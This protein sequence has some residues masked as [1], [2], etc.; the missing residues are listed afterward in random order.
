MQQT[1]L[2]YLFQIYYGNASESYA[3]QVLPYLE[4]KESVNAL[5]TYA[6]LLFTNMERLASG[7][8]NATA[9]ILI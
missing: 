9:C 4:E 2:R 7:L 1:L 3:I 5:S 8:K 6:G